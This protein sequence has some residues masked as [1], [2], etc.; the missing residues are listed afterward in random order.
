M[1]VINTNMKLPEEKIWAN[2][3]C[4]LDKFNF[5]Y[6]TDKKRKSISILNTNYKLVFNTASEP[7][8]CDVFVFSV[9]IYSGNSV[10][11]VLFL[12]YIMQNFED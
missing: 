1:A 6:L 9:K 11:A 7:W 2:I 10:G 3:E 12:N 4:M 5:Q 8:H